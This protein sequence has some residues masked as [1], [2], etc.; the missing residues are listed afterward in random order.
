M[1]KFFRSIRKDLMEKNK[2]GKYFKYAFGEIVLVVIGILIALSINN[3]NEKRKERIIERQSYENLITSLKKDS[4]ELA[5]VINF[6]QK[7]M[8]EQNRFINSDLS[9]IKAYMT[10]KEISKSLNDVYFGAY[11]F[12]PKY[13]TY[14][15]IQSNE[16]INLF[17]SK[18]IKSLLIELYDYQCKKYED[19]DAVIDYKFMHDFIPFSQ[20]HLGFFVDSNFKYKEINL[21]LFEKNYDELVLQCENLNVMLKQ[22]IIS[23]I[24]IQKTVN[25]LISHITK[26][27]KSL[28]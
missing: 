6:Q 7:S 10:I 1:I 14:N 24:D 4:L 28:K 2:T 9:E 5:R 15:A 21:N 16:G 12:F 25:E 20:R 8:V 3:W 17:S 27:L 13:G 23:L 26:E 22:S 11:S 19:Q 18:E